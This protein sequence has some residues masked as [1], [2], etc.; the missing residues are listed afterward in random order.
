MKI[1][2]NTKLNKGKYAGKT[3]LEIAPEILKGDWDYISWMINNWKDDFAKDV[4]DRH[5]WE[6]YCKKTGFGSG[7][8]MTNDDCW[9]NL[10]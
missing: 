5:G 9:N 8:G 4:M 6:A 2:L 1:T 3:I 10:S 7:G